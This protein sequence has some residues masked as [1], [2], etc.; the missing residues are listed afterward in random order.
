M[1]LKGP[2][3]ASTEWLLWLLCYE[4]SVI[5][6]YLA[7]GL[8]TT[9]LIQVTD[10]P[11]DWRT[12][13]FYEGTFSKTDF[14]LESMYS[15]STN[16]GSVECLS[17]DKLSVASHPSSVSVAGDEVLPEQ[18]PIREESARPA[19]KS[20]DV[21]MVCYQSVEG[22]EVGNSFFPIL[23][24]FLYLIHPVQYT[25]TVFLTIFFVVVNI[26]FEG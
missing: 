16:E 26:Y 4:D 20:N 12:W 1:Y 2:R 10:I 24:I 14:S 9:F 6:T 19:I 5:V 8:A 13:T 15:L 22:N 21:N 3:W 18:C 23:Q 17:F 11:L 7:H 25:L